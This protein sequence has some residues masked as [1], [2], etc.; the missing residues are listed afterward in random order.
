M[1]EFPTSVQHFDEG[2]G[3]AEIPVDL[4]SLL[5][6]PRTVTV[7]YEVIEGN[8]TD[9]A[10]IVESSG[11]LVFPAGTTQVLI[12]TP[13][14]QDL[15][16]EGDEQ[17]TVVL[18]NPV[19]AT[20]QDDQT[21]LSSVVI[22]KD[23][24]P[25]VTLEAAAAAVNEGSDV[26]FNLARSGDATDE[27]TV[28]LQVIEGAPKNASAQLTATFASGQD[29]TQLTVSTEDDSESLG[30]YIVTAL[31]ESPSSN[32]Q[33]PAYSIGS[34]LTASVIVRDNDLPAVS[35]IFPPHRER[36]GKSL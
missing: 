20:L 5:P 10:D 21:T 11:T 12:E 2:I 35:L 30:T 36:L 22:I 1:L 9:G 18:S 25:V 19:N 31:L 23:D 13:V 17:F 33:S 6:V 15:I 34:Q 7:D 27:L 14:I 28:G 29:T 24:E 3:N 16:A 32:G 8:H 4:T 26:V